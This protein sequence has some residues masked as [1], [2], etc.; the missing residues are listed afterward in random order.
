MWGWFRQRAVPLIVVLMLFLQFMT[1]QAVN[2][3]AERMPRDPPRCSDYD[4][5]SVYVKGTVSLDSN[6]RR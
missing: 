1:W 5:C 4:P 6:S 2:K 3:M